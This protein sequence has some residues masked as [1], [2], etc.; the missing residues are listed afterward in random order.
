MSRTD[1][2][3]KETAFK[4][5]HKRKCRF[6]I[7]GTRYSKQNQSPKRK[8]GAQSGTF[9]KWQ[10]RA[11]RSDATGL[12]GHFADASFPVAIVE[13]LCFSSLAVVLAL[14]GQNDSEKCVAFGD[15]ERLFGIGGG[16]QNLRPDSWRV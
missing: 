16:T 8:R 10:P 7:Y 6:L 14:D 4:K 13:Q 3:Y 5:Q 15:F 2:H 12:S 1:C 11:Q 9:D